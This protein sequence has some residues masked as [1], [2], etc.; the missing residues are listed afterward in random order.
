MRALAIALLLTACDGGDD[1]LPPD[2]QPIPIDELCREIAAKDCARLEACGTIPVPLDRA[3]CEVRQRYVACGPI[4]LA[5]RASV[6]AGSL[7]YFDLAARDCRSAIGRLPCDTGVDYDLLAIPECRDV[8]M[9]MAVEGSACH[10]P[11]A[12]GDAFYCAGASCPGECRAFRTSNQTCAAGQRCG[13]DLFCSVTGMRCRSRVALGAACELSLDNNPCVEGGFCDMSQPGVFSCV[14]VRGR[15]QGCNSSFECIA[16]ARCV[17]NRCSAGLEGDVCADEAPCAP[18]LACASG[19]CAIPL[20]LDATCTTDGVPCREGLTCTSSVGR[21]ACHRL[22]VAGEACDGTCY[23]G[24]CEGNTCAAAVLPD[25]ACSAPNA[26]LPGYGCRMSTCQ[27]D[28]IDC[29][30]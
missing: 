21:V 14:P 23:L 20:A 28:P 27:V 15:G 19:T 12:C 3:S 5:M 7:A 22:P 26:C 8:V 1:E 4:V 18:G 13:P 29:V 10:L 9:S 16:G 2:D 25:E 30:E 24:S 11:L 17:R 6:S